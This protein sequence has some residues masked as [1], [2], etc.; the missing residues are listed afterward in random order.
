MSFRILLVDPDLTAAAAAEQA[1]VKSGYRVAPVS[2]FE[3]ATR[4]IALDYPDM[5]VTAVRLGAF[6]GVHLLLRCREDHPDVPV[7]IMGSMA[8]HSS[9]IA[10]FGAC[11]VPTPLDERFFLETVGT[12]LAN[13]TPLSPGSARRWPRKRTELLALVSH[14]SARVVELSYGG[15]RLKMSGA[16]DQTRAP[17]D[18]RLPSLGVSV[19]AVPRWLK[20]SEDDGSWWCG[21]E[22]ALPGSED[23]RTWRD[24]VDSVN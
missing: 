20:P 15:V 13:R 10:R 23:I 1:L 11:F 19:K 9:D 6:N 21:A 24:I 16:P 22:M 3:E 18:I 5:L 14:N 4:Q 8:D 12:L 2:T 17:I 7:I